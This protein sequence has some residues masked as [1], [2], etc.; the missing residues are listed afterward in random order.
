MSGYRWVL[1]YNLVR[2]GTSSTLKAAHLDTISLQNTL[3]LWQK[4]LA[5]N[6]AKNTELI[7]LLVYQ[8]THANL[9]LS[10]L[11]NE[12]L[13]RALALRQACERADFC[14]YLASLERKV[15]G[16]VYE[17]YDYPRYRS[18]Y[19]TRKNVKLM[20]VTESFTRLKILLT[21][22]IVSMVSLIIM[23]RKSSHMFP[24]ALMI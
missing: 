21:T 12:D 19:G 7:Y 3:K 8:Y 1:T 10:C 23:A 5:A 22:I 9:K 13:D 17:E 6:P 18:S 20:K 14:F 11:K 16:G 4:A 24:S 15:W 2:N